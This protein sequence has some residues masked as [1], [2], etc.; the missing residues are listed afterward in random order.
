MDLN[1]K[2]KLNNDVE[3]PFLGLGTYLITGKKV[4]EVVHY[5]LEIGYRHFDTAKFYGNEK[6]LGEAIRDSSIP[7]EDIFITTKLWNSDHGYDSTLKAFDRSLQQLGLGYVDLYLIHWPVT[8]LRLESWRAMEKILDEGKCRAIG[9]SNYTIDHLQELL[10]H[11]PVVPTVNQV[12]FHP[13]LYQKELVDYCRSHNIVL[14]AYSPLTK[15]R[16]LTDPQLARLSM[17][18]ARSPAQILIRW[19][20]QHEIVVIPKSSNK[21]RIFEN[22]NVFDFDMLPEDMNL[23]DSFNRNFHVTW[24]PTD[25]S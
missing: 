15:G 21:R 17:K 22:A 4:K 2:I 3:I 24:D 19:C 16:R 11:S 10:D 7:K 5:A 1:S 14:E 12:E 20:L 13:W 18:Y 6:E 25:E 23:L 9:V 8:R